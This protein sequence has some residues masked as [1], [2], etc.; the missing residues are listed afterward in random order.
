MA[1]SNHLAYDPRSDSVL[2]PYPQ[3]WDVMA[4]SVVVDVLAIVLILKNTIIY[5]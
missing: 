3:S 1:L 2:E 5:D 4:S